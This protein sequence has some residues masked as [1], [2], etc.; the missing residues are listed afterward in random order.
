MYSVYTMHI[1]NMVRGVGSL[2]EIGDRPPHSDT[3]LLPLQTVDLLSEMVK[4]FKL[5]RSTTSS[6]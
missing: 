5:C 3:W 2:V 6:G 4:Q 1:Y